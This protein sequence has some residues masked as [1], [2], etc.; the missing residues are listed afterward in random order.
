MWELK[1]HRLR[2]LRDRDAMCCVHTQTRKHT[3]IYAH[4]YAHKLSGRSR[5]SEG[6]CVLCG[7]VH[8]Y[9]LIHKKHVRLLL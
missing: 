3:C 4:G 5:K 7:C 1:T 2:K 8:V 6:A 9:V